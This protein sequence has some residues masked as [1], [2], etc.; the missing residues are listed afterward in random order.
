MN[1]RWTAV[2]LV[3]RE[4]VSKD[5]RKYTF[6]LPSK[7]PLNLKTG[8][9]ILLGFHLKDKMIVRPYTPTKPIIESDEDGTFELVVKTYF[10]DDKT[11]GGTLSNILDIMPIGESIDIKGPTGDITYEK[12]GE[13]IIEGKKKKFDKVLL[14]LG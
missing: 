12:N 9:H 11:P 6:K 4:D 7:E 8:N 14:V 13:F 1:D 2:T 5:S 3:H 10:P